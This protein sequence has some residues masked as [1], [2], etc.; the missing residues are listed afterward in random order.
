MVV[1]Q[2]RGCMNSRKGLEV[3]KK[4]KVAVEG[5]ETNGK[6]NTIISLYI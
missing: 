2:S 6:D 5:K 1:V 4:W 3:T